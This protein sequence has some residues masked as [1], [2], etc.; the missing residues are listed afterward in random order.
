M[1]YDRENGAVYEEKQYGGKVLSFLYGNAIGR[2][3][4]KG[5]VSPCFSKLSGAYYSSNLSKRKIKPFVEKNSIDL[6]EYEKKEYNSFNDFFTRKKI[7]SPEF[8]NKEFISP[9]DSKLTV[10]R[11]EDDLMIKIKNS[12]YSIDELVN[13]SGIS[14]N[15]SGGYCFVF[16]LSMDD[17]HRYCFVD[18]GNV[19]EKYLVKGKLHTVSYIS[20]N[21]KVF[22]ENTRQVNVLS[23]NNFGKIVV[24]EVGAMLVGKFHDNEMTVFKKGDEKG[25]FELGGST[26]VILTEKGICVDEDILE[27]S[28]KGVE[29][30]VKY[31]QRIG[32]K[33]A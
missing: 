31:A 28:K 13:K 21:R 14:E 2:F 4:L 33:N 6:G 29:T 11:I 7:V 9:A 12:V 24:V 18:D 20:E 19:E 30:K 27:Q 10:Y 32:E 8:K 17:C 5:A 23:T 15:F 26:I 3:L 1:I 25:Y 22:C 16:R